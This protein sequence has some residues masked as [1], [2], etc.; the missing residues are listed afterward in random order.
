MRLLLWFAGLLAFGYGLVVLLMY[1]NQRSFLY[2]PERERTTPA[3]AGF[4]ASRELTLETRDGERV[5][6]WH[7]PPEGDR[8]VI[9]Y[10]HGN[11]GSL[12]LRAER[13]AALTADGT[14]LVAL[15]YRGYGGSSGVP[16]EQG[17][18]RDAEAAYRFAAEHYPARRIVLWGESLGTGVAVAIAAAHPIG[19]LILESPFTST[20]DVA[21]AIY[22]FL[23]VRLLMQ[24][25]FPS[26]QRISR[27]TAPVLVMHGDRD[28]TVPIGY[29]ER[30]F[31]M[32]KAPKQFV[33]FA[34]GGHSD[35]D[36]FGALAAVRNFLNKI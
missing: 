30:L 28:A 31:A 12:R 5:I 26:D 3:A 6:A 33:R 17:L 20:V 22:W 1:F 23:P 13:F 36:S 24:D 16:T 10:F 27:V 15:S 18:I 35:L 7:L 11:G 9:L 8:P 34:G 2:F 4:R 32:I 29:G 25:Q 14:G 21:A 19:G